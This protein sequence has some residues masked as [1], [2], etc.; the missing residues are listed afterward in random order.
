[1]VRTTAWINQ[2]FRAGDILT[3][4][5]IKIQPIAFWLYLLELLC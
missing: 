1:L 5:T 4:T 3:N 2:I